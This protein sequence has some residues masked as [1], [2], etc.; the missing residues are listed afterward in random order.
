MVAFVHLCKRGAPSWGAGF[1]HQ[2]R[3]QQ[4][5]AGWGRQPA[6]VRGQQGPTLS[7]ELAAGLQLSTA[8]SQLLHNPELG[9]AAAHVCLLLLLAG[10][11]RAAGQDAHAGLGLRLLK[12]QAVGGQLLVGGRHACSAWGAWWVG[13]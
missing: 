4:G 3:E 5:A 8:A 9:A 1:D 10:H 11:H 12:G 13:G 7:G 6:T 2:D